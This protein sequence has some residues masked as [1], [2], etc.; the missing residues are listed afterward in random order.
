MKA[1]VTGG[2]GCVGYHVVLELLEEGWEVIVF[3]RETSN[4]SMFDSSVT[5][6]K[7]NL[8]DLKSTIDSIP[9]GIDAVFHLAANVAHHTDPNQ[10][11]DNVLVTKNLIEAAIQKKVGRFIFTSTAA[12]RFARDTSDPKKLAR[13]IPSGYARTKRLAEIVVLDAADRGLDIV[14]LQPTI[15]LGEFD[16]HRNYSQLFEKN[17][18]TLIRAS[19]PGRLEFA[20]AKK[21]AQAHINAYHKGESNCFYVLGGAYLSWFELQ[22]VIASTHGEKPPLFTLPN[23][24]LYC[25]AIMH[26]IGYKLFGVHPQMTTDLIWLLG[27]EDPVQLSDSKKAQLDLEYSNKDTDIREVC[28]RMYKWIQS[29]K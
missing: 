4:T 25:I 3:H 24:F 21:I 16:F 7:V 13:E 19:L 27:D 1:I 15:V 9:E 10:W 17:L 12:A 14:I 23:W 2:T 18:L 5:L 28:F 20:D 6:V 8:Y 29:Q 22:Q 11:K 26:A